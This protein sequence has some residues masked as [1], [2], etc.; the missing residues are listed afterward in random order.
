[1]VYNIWTVLVTVR[2]LEEALDLKRALEDNFMSHAF[3]LDKDEDGN[4]EVCILNVGD[5]E[6]RPF[7]TFVWG[8]FRGRSVQNG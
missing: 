2:D 3:R 8:Y 4:N 1:M 5:N 7:Q 6:L